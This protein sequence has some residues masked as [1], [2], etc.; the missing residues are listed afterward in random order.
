MAYSDKFKSSR[1]LFIPFLGLQAL[2]NSP[3][4]KG[5]EISILKNGLVSD[6]DL[7]PMFSV[8]R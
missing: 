7:D 4:A 1:L 3:F 6:Y 8:D 5:E 2:V